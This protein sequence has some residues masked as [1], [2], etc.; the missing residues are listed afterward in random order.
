[1]G[2]GK[3]DSNVTPIHQ[4]ILV[5]I[6]FQSLNDFREPCFGQLQAKFAFRACFDK[7]SSMDNL[8]FHC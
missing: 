7:I 3:I 5:M 6:G 1:M 8:N 4:K 2:H